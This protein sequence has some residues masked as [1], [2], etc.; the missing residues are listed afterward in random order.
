[1]G[2]RMGHPRMLSD[3]SFTYHSKSIA[4]EAGPADFAYLTGRGETPLRWGGTGAPALG[5]AG[6]V[7]K[8]QYQRVFAAGARHP[9]TGERLGVSTTRRG[10][11][12]VFNT[13]KSV[14]ILGLVMNGHEADAQA[15]MDAEVA[16]NLRYLEGVVRTAGGRRGREQ[17]RVETGGLVYASTRHLY[18]RAMDPDIHQHVLIAN[19]VEM[20]DE[21]GGWKALDSSLLHKHVQAADMHGRVAGAWEARRRGYAIEGAWDRRQM[22]RPE[23]ERGV[24]TN[25]RIAG[26]PEEVERK[27]SKRSQEI[28]D[29]GKALGWVDTDHV[30]NALARTT[31]DDKRY[32][33]IGDLKP[34]WEAEL[35]EIGVPQIVLESGLVGAA[36]SYQQ[37]ELEPREVRAAGLLDYE[38]GALGSR[39]TWCR[40]D[41]V[42][43]AGPALFGVNPAELDRTVT[44]V[45]LDSEA[46]P[47]FPKPGVTEPG[48]STATNLAIEGA[49][50]KATE[51][52]MDEPA[53]PGPAARLEEVLQARF[54]PGQQAAV[55][56]V[57]EGGHRMDLICGVAGSGKTTALTAIRE[58][59]EADGW[60]VRGTSTSGAAARTLQQEAGM[61]SNTIRSLL[62]QVDHG[63]LT[64]DDRTLLVLDEAGMT[65]DRHMLRLLR[66][67]E[68]GGSRIVMVGDHRQLP[69]VDMGGGFEALQRRHPDAVHDLSDNVRQV[70]VEERQ[71][72]AELR[73]GRV[74]DAVAWYAAHD[75]LSVSPTGWEAVGA[76]VAAWAVDVADGKDA[77]MFAWTR[78][79][80]RALNEAARVSQIDAG[81]VD[82]GREVETG[83]GRRLAVGDRVVTLAGDSSV[84]DARVVTSE[85]GW[86]VDVGSQDGQEGVV[87]ELD[88]GV[89]HTYIGDRLADLDLGYATTV[90]RAQGSTC[91]RAHMLADGGGRELS[92][93][94][95]SRAREQSIAYLVADTVDQAV[96]DLTVAWRR[97]AR[98]VWTHDSDH[99]LWDAEQVME[100]RIFEWPPVDEPV[101]QVELEQAQ[102]DWEIS[103]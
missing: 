17:R 7:T 24:P 62:W 42:V 80:V 73:A 79:H 60:Q 87:V 91:D 43:A 81:R 99:Q 12:I 69:A 53:Q 103:L 37:P 64:F 59:Y 27:F 4:D 78:A 71:V 25:W 19:I 38:D 97:D 15:I 70:D 83:D 98:E 65:S 39:K 9:E 74:A 85:K 75:R 36:M 92:Y 32:A 16:A 90:H 47:L 45:Q 102:D 21:Q 67:A 52:A 29:E 41:A 89:R 49:V 26:I 5:L 11:E 57:C 84:R 56:A 34:G 1:M 22:L 54:T 2:L 23:A 10:V 31:R 100:A 88:S 6:R 48:W 20:A 95:M 30:R 63:R 94:G 50:A 101:I 55:R 35:R 3:D 8:E 82:V 96:E 18:S 13:R 40:R 61:P 28:D 33:D 44:A 58:A 66:A 93:V 51:R 86:V 14:S 46:V 77:A 76:A 68:H 72:L